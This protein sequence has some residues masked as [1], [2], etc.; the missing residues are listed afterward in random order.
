MIF[1]IYTVDIA[2]KRCYIVIKDMNSYSNKPKTLIFLVDPGK[3]T[4]GFAADL[5]L[6]KR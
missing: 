3:R 5:L 1:F 6:Y 2:G 4:A